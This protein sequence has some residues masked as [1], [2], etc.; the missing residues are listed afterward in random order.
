MSEF[1]AF[2]NKLILHLRIN[3]S[4]DELKVSIQDE[5]E[6]AA[7]VLN[8]I[9]KFLYQRHATLEKEYISEFHKY[10]KYNHEK[11][12]QPFIG[13]KET[14]EVA[15]V[16]ENVYAN[17]T[18]RVQLNTL[19]LI[20]EEIANVRFFTAIQDFKIDISARINPFELY[21]LQPD[22]FNASKV[23]DNELL[24]DEFLNRIGAESQRDKRKPWMQRAAKLLKDKYGS[25]AFNI[26]TVHNGDVLEIKKAL[27]ESE[28]YGFAPK[29]T[30]MFL[31]DMA[32]LEVWTY[33][34]N[35][36]EINVMSDKNTMRIAL[37]TGILQFRIPLLAS[38]LDVYC[39]QYAL[40]DKWNV[41]AWRQVWKIWDTL[42]NNHRPPTPASIDYFIYR[43]GKLACWKAASRRRCPPSRPVSE[44]WLR[45]KIPQDQLLFN[46][47]FYC[48]F[49]NICKDER[50]ILNHP[51]SISIKGSTG[52]ESGKTN[53]GGGGGIQS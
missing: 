17:N 35:I 18:I 25:S 37:R 16:L 29:K 40:V 12:L 2:L 43:M 47:N 42:P 22:F 44:N 41:K 34:K 31:R 7:K 28:G 8:E 49:E 13:K 48:I 39:Y 1:L 20:P 23:L 10:W 46:E 36:E 38:Y 27:A 15:K 3:I 9:N 51:M 32:D 45:S 4:I 14:L 52:W 11:V 6:I 5:Y 33:K 26:N 50:K 30:D 24:I 19:D 21:G 53:E